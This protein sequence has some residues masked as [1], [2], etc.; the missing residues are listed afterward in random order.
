VS[1]RL[2]LFAFLLVAP[3]T[4]GAD[5]VHAPAPESPE[6]EES[7]VVT[8]CNGRSSDGCLCMQEKKAVEL[9]AELRVCRDSTGSNGSSGWLVG[10]LAM[11]GALL[12]NLARGAFGL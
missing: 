10:V 3:A 1:V 9:I 4:V 12:G 11:V 2:P 8:D 6:E 7:A 5:E